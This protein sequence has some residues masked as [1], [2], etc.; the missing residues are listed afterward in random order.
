MS[1]PIFLNSLGLMNPYGGQPCFAIQVGPYQDGELRVVRFHGTERLN[2]PFRYDMTIATTLAYGDVMKA[3][4]GQ[5][6]RFAMEAPGSDARRV[7]GIIASFSVLGAA[8]R[9]DGTHV[10]HYGV[11][12]VPRLQLLSKRHAHRVFEN[13]TLLGIALAVLADARITPDVRLDTKPHLPVPFIMQRGESDLDFVNRIFALAGISYYF[14]HP[15]GKPSDFP[16]RIR[17]QGV[18]PPP[19]PPPAADGINSNEVMVIVDA[20]SEMTALDGSHSPIGMPN[21]ITLAYSPG[22]GHGI[23]QESIRTF[24]TKNEI[25]PCKVTTREWSIFDHATTEQIATFKT[26]TSSAESALEVFEYQR[27]AALAPELETFQQQALAARSLARHR[28]T[29]SSASGTSDS[30]RLAPGVRFILGTSNDPYPIDDLQVPYYV[31]AV[32]CEGTNLEELERNETVDIYKNEFECA[33]ASLDPRPPKPAER[34]QLGPEAATVIGPWDGCWEGSPYS[35]EKGRILVRF[36]RGTPRDPNKAPPRPGFT[37]ECAV[38]WA[39]RWAGD[40][41][42]TWT[43]PR[44]GSEVLV[45]FPRQEGASPIATAQLYSR[46]N[47]PPFA[48]LDGA[49]TLKVGIRSQ[50]RSATDGTVTGYSE[51][52]IEDSP[53]NPTVR[54]IAQQDMETNI[55]GESRTVI[56]GPRH[57]RTDGPAHFAHRSDVNVDVAMSLTQTILNNRT[58]IVRGAASERVDG[59]FAGVLGGELSYEC[60]GDATLRFGKNVRATSRGTI[61]VN[62]DQ[63][64]VVRTE[65]HHVT[66]VGTPTSER[67][68]VTSV[69]GSAQTHATGTYELQAAKG[70]TLR[71]GDSLFVISPAGIHIEGPAVTMAAKQIQMSG[72]QL[73]ATFDNSASIGATNVTLSTSSSTL[74]VADKIALTSSAISLG[75][76]SGSSAQSSNAPKNPTSLDLADQDGNPLAGR[77]YVLVFPD[78]SETSGVLDSNGHA[79]LGEQPSAFKVRFPDLPRWHKA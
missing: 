14:E 77:R 76:G 16:Q 35:D 12:I 58:A 65:G 5:P 44:V 67:S 3:I 69:A 43:L 47:S 71:S 59:S 38:V 15:V 34:P 31:T 40:G 51:I 10:F 17:F 79:D 33:P 2:A 53:Y 30:R 22:G 70:I 42:G 50:S 49:D 4:C 37:G 32:R 1:A 45:D 66:V 23:A 13:Q 62:S 28:G 24:V 11:S 25:A 8:T 19:I 29:T 36:H 72:S 6:V 21:D 74:T 68:A 56:E 48:P 75:S 46:G 61:H 7:E 39:E 9:Q 63:D 18:A 41:Y 26:D 20:A 55:G 78:G 73:A 64:V 54:V 52:S 57:E 27:E 60:H